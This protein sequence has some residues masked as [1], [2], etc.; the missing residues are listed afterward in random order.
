MSNHYGALMYYINEIL[1]A[2]TPHLS[3]RRLSEW[4]AYRQFAANMCAKSAKFL[5][6]HKMGAPTKWEGRAFATRRV[7][8]YTHEVF[9]STLW[10]C[11]KERKQVSVSEGR[12]ITSS[13]KSDFHEE[14]IDQVKATGYCYPQ[15]L[16]I[17]AKNV[18]IECIWS[19]EQERYYAYGHLL[20]QKLVVTSQCASV[21]CK[22]AIMRTRKHDMYDGKIIIIYKY[23]QKLSLR[24]LEVISGHYFW[25]WLRADSV[26]ER[27]FE[28]WIGT[29]SDSLLVISFLNPR[30]KFNLRW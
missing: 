16:H 26:S 19:W 5:S 7:H 9:E 3:S 11:V 27:T 23:A 15:E 10:V 4:A 28:S 6:L 21:I 8:L 12:A 20:I 18:I 30:R 22:S 2:R 14:L 17:F 13:T 1:T 25:I 29:S 24:S